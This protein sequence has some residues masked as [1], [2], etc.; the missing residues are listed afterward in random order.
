MKEEKKLSK[1][2]A[3]FMIVGTLVLVLGFVS[4]PARAELSLSLVGGY[5]SP[6]FGEINDDQWPHLGWCNDY[7][8]TDLGFEAGM[9][10]GLAL[11]Y[12]LDQRFRLRLEY[13]SFESKTSDDLWAGGYH[14]DVDFKL[15]V[16]SVI[17]SGIY[18][19]SPPYI[20]AGIGSFSTEAIHDED[21]KCQVLFPV[22]R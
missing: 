11:G 7:Y 1:K 17:L 15:T 3:G 4:T 6:N 20:G 5:Y 19:F 22:L 12:D 10:S 2:I 8:G 9:M 18:K 13:N 21:C 14:W 16:T